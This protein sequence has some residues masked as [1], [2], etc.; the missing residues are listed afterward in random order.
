VARLS[1]AG[2]DGTRSTPVDPSLADRAEGEC[3]RSLSET[4]AAILNALP[5]HVALLDAQ[6]VVVAANDAWRR[7]GADN[8]LPADGEV[9]GTNY[10]DVCERAVGACAEE[11]RAV[12]D[13]IRQV[14]R[15]ATPEF[16]VEYPCHAPDQQR[17]FRV[18]VTPVRD[19]GPGGAVVT[20][21]DVTQRKLAEDALRASETRLR[22][23]VESEPECVKTVSVDGRL[24]DMNP[25]GLRMVEADDAAELIGQ[26]VLDLIHPDDRG[27]FVD[28][29]RRVS[30]GASGELQFRIVGRKGTERWVETHS[31]PLR[32]VDGT[33]GAV[34]SVTRDVTERRRQERLK[35]CETK[36]LEAISTG[37]R[38]GTILEI[39]ALGIE[40]VLGDGQV[41]VLLLDEDGRHVRHAAAPHLP[42][43]YARTIDGEAIGP[44]AGSCGTAAYRKEP[45]A[46]ED[47]ARDPLWADYR[48]LALAHGLR[49]CWSTPVI[50]A[51]GRVLATFAVYHRE[52]RRPRATDQE[53]I[54]RAV[55]LVRLAVQ[56]ARREDALRASEER[57]R[58]ALRI[59]RMGGWSLDLTGAEPRM[60]GSPE[61]NE[62]FGLPRDYVPDMKREIERYVP[63]HRE[64]MWS[65]LDA[66]MHEGRA[67]DLQLEVVDVAGRRLWTRSI[68][69]ALR[70]ESGRIVGVQGAFQDISAQK[71]AEQSLAESQR[72]FRDLADAMP[73]I[74][75]TSLPHGEVDYVNQAFARY[76]G[77]AEAD[78][79]NSGWLSAV[80]PDDVKNVL[81]SASESIV[82]GTA[83]E[84]QFR[85]RRASDGAY[86]WHQVGAVPV[87][88]A[89]GQIVKWYGSAADIDDVVRLE[90]DASALAGRL[91]TTLESITDAFFTVDR[92]W[93]FTY[94]NAEAERK[95]GRKREEV[96]GKIL[97]DAFPDARGSIFEQ[98]YRR[99]VEQN[100]AVTFEA[101]YAPIDRWL[102]IRAFP[103]SEGL[104][105]YFRDVTDLRAAREAMQESEER[106][107]LLAKATNDAIWDWNYVSDELWWNEGFETL[108]GFSRDEIP[109]TIDSWYDRI[110]PDERESVVASV[111][112]A[113][114]AGAESWV[115]DYRFLRKDG[116]YAYVLDRGHVIRDAAGKA[117]RMIGGMT[118]LTERR[119]AE[120]RLAEQAALLDAAHEA[121]VVNDLDGTII[122]W[123]RGAERTFGWLASEAV[124]KR[125]EQLLVPEPGAYAAAQRLLRERGEWQGELS[126]RTKDGQELV[127]DVH[128][129]LVRDAMGRPK[130]VLAIDADVTERKR[131][132]QQFFRA[133]RMESIGTLA[134]GIAHDLNNLLAPISMGVELMKTYELDAKCGQILASMEL[135][136]RR[137]IDLVKQV[138]FFARG[139]EGSR[140]TVAIEDVTR[141]VESIVERTFPKAL[142]LTREI[143]APPWPVL[144]DPTQLTQVLLNL[145]VNARD[146]MPDGGRLGI[147]V[148]NRVFDDTYVAMNRGVAAGRYVE[149]E[150]TDTGCGIPAQ[151]QDRI[152]E[153]FF[154]T[155]EIGKGTGLGLSTVIGIVRSHGGFVSVYSELGKGTAFRVC[156][157]AREDAMARG[158]PHGAVGEPLPRGNGEL[159]LV[160]DDEA[161]IL[162]ITRQTLE[163]FGY[164]ALTAEDGAQ[165][166][167][168]FA[169][170]GAEVAAVVTDM[171]MPVM[172]GLALIAALRRIDPDVRVIASSGLNANGNVAR[173]AHADVKHFLAKPYSAEELLQTLRAVLTSA[174]GSRRPHAAPPVQA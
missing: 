59:S 105:G 118:D 8:G 11:A 72:R 12:A 83:H 39:T 28:L 143:C 145:C 64:T 155:K 159:V 84:V 80:H 15:G 133:Q 24:L 139:M 76:A 89:A 171:M 135:S 34:L 56:R 164:R 170:H 82:R 106:F 85:L 40:E 68:G 18:M 10:L 16:S 90:Q 49:A 6:G 140:V 146:A 161:S 121:I 162:H 9:I 81:S 51:D 70:D 154:T 35:A 96:L 100:V 147:V 54:D 149:I 109:P 152:F 124:G 142:H 4:Q 44:I 77:I 92:D 27:R 95:I 122:Y 58:M 126:K 47:I 13:G 93:R 75:F 141:E 99:A 14:L 26:P 128:W 134:G 117:V 21:V 169:L 69:E 148:R 41:S 113:V 138:L 130:S 173:V 31:T 50:D 150:V 3:F 30:G 165:A 114:A 67:F 73:I 111:H 17:W 153:P 151:I 172:D 156:L 79:G 104:A 38:L 36:V 62:V 108:F 55:H 115:R 129:T 63:E 163:A 33:I 166:I 160:V 131:L 116:S 46:V 42:A 19:I 88:D 7:F 66:C 23:I 144:G 112:A 43:A 119:Q 20:H 25:A 157:P 87:R 110:H 5:A 101:H 168:L 167:A 60:H 52:P 103:S 29:H 94:W 74:V 61:V 32:D 107:R 120:E 53:V 1:R 48:E 158:V 45:V 125:H 174:D 22:A 91:V 57:L 136:A 65:A 132:E 98:H 127:V 102:E 78:L 123:N 97:W 86:R 137:G 2:F 37:Q 71:A